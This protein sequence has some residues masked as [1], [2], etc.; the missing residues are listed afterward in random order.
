MNVTCARGSLPRAFALLSMT[1][2]GLWAAAAMAATAV[3]PFPDRPMRLIVGF[4]PGSADDYI[5]RLLAP[6]LT[7]RLGQ[8]VIVDNRSGVAGHLAA[9]LAGSRES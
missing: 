6:K 2:A 9:E 1:V 5:A 7:E 3:A 4:T 8:T